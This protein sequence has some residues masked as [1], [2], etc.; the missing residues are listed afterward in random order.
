[1]KLENG[2]EFLKVSYARL[3]IEV[4]CHSVM[5]CVDMYSNAVQ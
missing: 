4:C 1:M 2:N 5:V 3:F